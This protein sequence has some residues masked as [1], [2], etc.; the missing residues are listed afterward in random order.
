MA[1]SWKPEEEEIK[2]MYR[3]IEVDQL[4]PADLNDYLVFIL[5]RS[6]DDIGLEDEGHEDHTIL[7]TFLMV[8][9]RKG[10]HGTLMV[11]E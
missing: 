3:L 8:R 9:L 5:S 11:A 4:F 2:E 7:Y 6:E 10:I 1:S